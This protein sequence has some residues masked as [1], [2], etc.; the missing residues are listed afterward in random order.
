[1]QHEMLFRIIL[2]NILINFVFSHVTKTVQLNPLVRKKRYL[3]FPEDSNLVLTLSLLKALLIVQPRGWNLALEMDIPFNL[4]SDTRW[5]K[6]RKLHKRDVLFQLEKAFFQGGL[7]G[8]ACVKR[9]ICD[10]HHYIHTEGKSLVANFLSAIFMSS[11]IDFGVRYE[12]S[13][14]AIT[15]LEC[16]I[17]FLSYILG[18]LFTT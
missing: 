10:A 17:P 18:S 2:I 16:E 1:M 4:P 6:K 9:M 8:S 13:C 12:D 3:T 15:A 7:N 14:R 5:F 11:E